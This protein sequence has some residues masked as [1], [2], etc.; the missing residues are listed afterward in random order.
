MAD[1]TEE[2]EPEPAN[3]RGGQFA[4][5]G[6]PCRLQCARIVGRKESSES[7]CAN[8]ASKNAAEAEKFGTFC[9][10]LLV[11]PTVPRSPESSGRNSATCFGPRLPSSI[12]DGLDLTATAGNRTCDVR[13]VSHRCSH[14]MLS[15]VIPTL[16]LL[17]L[18]LAGCCNVRLV[19]KCSDRL[20]TTCTEGSNS[21]CAYPW[22]QSNA[23]K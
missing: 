2:T 9:L 23:R 21:S 3:D 15:I 18:L 13:I 11:R 14:F 1:S 19:Q 16:S 20:G 6:M 8:G 4:G 22:L 17:A 10:L 7:T 5:R 12:G